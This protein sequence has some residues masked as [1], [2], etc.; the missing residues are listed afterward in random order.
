[1]PD[2]PIDL[3]ALLSAR[4]HVVT[5]IV[6]QREVSGWLSYSIAQSMT[7]PADAFT[8]S[9]PFDR[10]AWFTCEPD[11]RINVIVDGAPVISGILDGRSKSAADGTMEITGRD[12]IGRLVQE[13]ADRDS[14][15]NG[16]LETLLSA[17]MSP[18]FSKLTFDAG[19]DRD[20]RRG[21]GRHHAAAGTEPIVLKN[22]VSK[23]GKIEPGQFKWQLI[24]QI[25][26]EAGLIAYSSG[27]GTELI[28]TKP[29]YTQG[30]QYVC[31]HVR[32]GSQFDSTTKD[33]RYSENLADAYAH[34]LCI[35]TGG[36]TKEDYASTYRKGWK[37]DGPNPNGTGDLFHLPKSLILVESAMRSNKEAT[38]IAEREWARRLFKT[39]AMTAVMPFHGQLSAGT[40]KTLFAINTIAQVIDEEIDFEQNMLVHS[41]RFEASRD[42]GEQTTLEM[43]PVGT[44]IAL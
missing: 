35:G 32:S 34:Y 28:V 26:S 41:V 24:Q 13:S 22:I 44:E 43:V 10:D 38:A 16:T 39:K 36:T 1:M 18:W 33:L 25:C 31:R 14:Y 5:V 3:K 30:V 15:D 2:K 20:V 17:L 42:G 11:T 23:Y 27:D 21:K 6:N 40:R 12:H 7:T 19:L 9:R 37:H 8:L 4:E 29:N